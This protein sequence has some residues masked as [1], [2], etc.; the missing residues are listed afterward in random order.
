MTSLMVWCR[1][2]KRWIDAAIDDN[3]Q[4]WCGVCKNH[5]ATVLVPYSEASQ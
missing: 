3:S 4:A 5:V 1:D 2:C